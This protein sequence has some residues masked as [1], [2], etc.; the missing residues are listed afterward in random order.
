MQNKTKQENQMTKIKLKG[1]DINTKGTLPAVGSIAPDF[2]FVKG[3][4]SEANLY[5]F[6]GKKIL[7][8]FPSIDTGTCAMSVRTF[9]KSATDL[10]N[11]VI[12]NIS[13]D[14]PFAQ[15]RFCGAEGIS[16]VEMGSVFRTDFLQKYP[17]EMTDGPLKGLCSRSLIVLNEK[18]EITFTEQVSD[19]V[20]EPNYDAALTAIKK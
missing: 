4:L 3:D 13:M 19:I 10:G 11:T 8:I 17:L 16:N 1:N 2:T 7:N 5:S 6:T 18:N 15:K 14:L 20:N 9:S 12:L